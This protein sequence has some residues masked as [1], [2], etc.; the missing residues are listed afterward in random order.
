MEASP[1]NRA[2]L[3]AGKQ[4]QTSR[5]SLSS[6][7]TVDSLTTAFISPDGESLLSN[8]TR[9]KTIKTNTTFQPGLTICCLKNQDY[10]LSFNLSTVS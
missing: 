10:I 1:G 4:Q 5:N 8:L 2:V 6:P 9:Q 3:G 7:L